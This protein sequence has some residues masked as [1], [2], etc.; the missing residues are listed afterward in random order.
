VAVI[1]S[2]GVPHATAAA[3]AATKTIPVVFITGTDP[4]KLGWVQSLNRP[5]GNVTGVSFLSNGLEAKRLGLLHDT[6]TRVTVVGVLLN[7][8]NPTSQQQTK[9][10]NDAAHSLGLTLHFA[11]V[12]RESDVEPAF[13]SV[14][15]R[16]AQA[17]AVT[18][19]GGFLAWPEQFV[20]QTARARIP[21]IFHDREFALRGGLSS[22]DASITAAYRLA[23]N[24]AGRILQGD[25]PGNLPVQQSTGVEFV[26]NLATAK[27]LG[28]EISSGVLAIADEV[29][30]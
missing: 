18:T 4:V 11:N 28:L 9:D 6:V 15:Q 27:S 23:G 8:E 1:V 2:T 20:A 25:K 5:G 10:L 30:E 16:G 17:I 24:Y 12:A 13:N 7:P 19:D 22:Y 3:L 26:I 21:A 29:I 14:L